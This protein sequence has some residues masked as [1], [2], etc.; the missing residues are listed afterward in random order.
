MDNSEIPNI[1]PRDVKCE[2]FARGR[3]KSKI[4]D[5]FLKKEMENMDYHGCSKLRNI[6]MKRYGLARVT[7]SDTRARFIFYQFQFEFSLLYLFN[8][9][10]TDLFTS[11]R[12]ISL[13][14]GAQQ[15]YFVLFPKKSL[16][17]DAGHS[18]YSSVSVVETNYPLHI[19]KE[20]PLLTTPLPLVSYLKIA[21]RQSAFW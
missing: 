4:L 19:V 12:R 17:R 20:A 16:F 5:D 9:V 6:L 18:V 14:E 3:E 8:S 10:C 2:N 13:P 7:Q 1:L 21:L 11:L 15:M